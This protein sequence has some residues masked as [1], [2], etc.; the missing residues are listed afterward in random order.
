M[1]WGGAG[2]VTC[3]SAGAAGV[4][5]GLAALLNPAVAFAGVAMCTAQFIK[6]W[7]GGKLSLLAFGSLILGCCCVV[8]PWVHRNYVLF[9]E[10]IPIRGNLG[11]E[12]WIGNHPG[13]DGTTYSLVHGP[14]YG[15]FSANHPFSS[16]LEQQT[17]VKLG[18]RRYMKEKMDKAV[19]WI[20]SNPG[21]FAKLTL[22]RSVLFWFPPP[23]MWLEGGALRSPAMRLVSLLGFCGLVSLFLAR[24]TDRWLFAIAVVI[25]SIPY[26][27]THVDL[28]YRYS[29]NSIVLLLS[30]IFVDISFRALRSHLSST[31]MRTGSAVVA[32]FPQA[33]EQLRP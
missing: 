6:F 7:S 27:V 2:Q 28:R 14:R 1:G 9:G 25:P 22:R 3:Q 5:L 33:S 4:V 13:S 15:F 20:R 26:F 11:L 10:F 29:V 19:F 12:M 8:A 18:E 31:L 24:H 16:R 23:K 21:Q 32:R 17:L 30:V